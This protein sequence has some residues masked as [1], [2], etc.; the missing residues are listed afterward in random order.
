MKRLT[1][2]VF[3]CASF[4]LVAQGSQKPNPARAIKAATKA[5][6]QVA[7][8]AVTQPISQTPMWNN[9]IQPV[10]AGVIGHQPQSSLSRDSSSESI[11]DD[12]S[13]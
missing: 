7:S 9:R 5:V 13:L 12:A 8:K 3:I 11:F 10:T 4:S 6:A 2:F 1:L